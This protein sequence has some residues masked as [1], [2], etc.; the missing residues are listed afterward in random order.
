MVNLIWLLLGGSA[1]RRYGLRSHD[2][3]CTVSNLDALAQVIVLDSS[4]SLTDEHVR[5]QF[6]AAKKYHQSLVNAYGDLAEELLR[7]GVIQFSSETEVLS[8]M[9]ND[10]NI[11]ENIQLNHMKLNTFLKPAIDLCTSMLS[12]VGEVAGKIP[13]KKCVMFLD[14]QPTDCTI[15]SRPIPDT[16]S[17]EFYEEPKLSPYDERERALYRMRAA[18]PIQRCL[19]GPKKLGIEV[20][21]IY[22]NQN[23]RPTKDALPILTEL[24]GCYGYKLT[25]DGD[26]SEFV[27]VD[28]DDEICQNMRAITSNGQFSASAYDSL[29]TSI[30]SSV[31]AELNANSKIE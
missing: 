14:G 27:G 31:S 6:K 11:M 23:R 29:R 9:T 3:E 16:T 8:E 28:A 18:L 21:A 5:E 15:L 17:F 26:I 19:S 30:E 10:I 4:N 7:F 25:Q 24:G 13:K 22:A 2:E 20:Q 12:G 1:A